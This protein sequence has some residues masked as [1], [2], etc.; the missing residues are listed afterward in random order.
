MSLTFSFL[1]YP[2]VRAVLCDI[3]GTLTWQG[4]ALPGAAQALSE[5]RRRGIALRFLTNITARQPADLA[6]ELTEFGVSVDACELMT[7][8]TACVHYLAQRPGLR[9]HFI[10]PEAVK[11]AFATFAQ[12]K[13]HPQAVVIGDIGEGFDYPTLNH[14]FRLLRQ[15]AELIALQHNLFWFDV[16]GARLDC[17]AFVTA[18]E[19]AAGIRATVTGKPSP[20]FFQQALD[21][22]EL[23]APEVL[24]V[25][26][27][28]ATDMEG[29]IGIGARAL[30]VHTGKSSLNNAPGVRSLADFP[31]IGSIADLPRWLDEQALRSCEQLQS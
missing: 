29:A 11:P 21:E 3:D 28:P 1:K 19:A 6:Q 2:P 30:L 12:D 8:T 14:A 26:D 7:A 24:V 18:L 25:G 23:A 31:A 27:D 17:G 5:L 20:R 22:L 16:N 15:G 13:Q 9:C 4:Q 10:L